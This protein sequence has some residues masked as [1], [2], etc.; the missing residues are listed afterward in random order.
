M[1]DLSLEPGAEDLMSRHSKAAL[2]VSLRQE[3]I[4]QYQ[5]RLRES[6]AKWQEVSDVFLHITPG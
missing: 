5:S 6:E 2:K 4:R 1:S 3:Q